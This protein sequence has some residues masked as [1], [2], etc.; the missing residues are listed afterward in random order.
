MGHKKRHTLSECEYHTE[1]REYGVHSIYRSK[2]SGHTNSSSYTIDP[3]NTYSTETTTN[4]LLGVICFFF[5][6]FLFSLS[7]AA[8]PSVRVCLNVL[9]VTNIFYY[10]ANN[11]L[12]QA[13]AIHNERTKE[14]TKNNE[15]KQTHGNETTNWTITTTTTKIITTTTSNRLCA[16]KTNDVRRQYVIKLIRY[17]AYTSNVV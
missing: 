16:T 11:K 14:R 9:F 3:A 8:I 6:F 2:L 17:T 10:G 4:W 7:A 5:F 13:Y 12:F 1:C 15:K